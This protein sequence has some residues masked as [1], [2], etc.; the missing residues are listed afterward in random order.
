MPDA[1][2]PRLAPRATILAVA[3][4]VA[5]PAG[6][7]QA[8]VRLEQGAGLPFDES[9]LVEA[10]ALRA[11]AQAAANGVVTVAVTPSG[12]GRVA[13]DTGGRRI[14][15]EVGP[16]T[17]R[18]AARLVALLVIDVSLPSLALAEER[19]APAPG[20]LSL[21]ATPCLN[22]GLSD[23]GVSFEPT[24]GMQWRLADRLGLVLSLGYARALAV[25]RAGARVLTFDTVPLRAGLA[26][27]VGS[28]GLQAGLL[29]RGFRA[30]GV[31]AALGTR[32][33]GW[34]AASWSLPLRG[35]LRPFAIVALDAYAEKLRLDRAGRP[36]LSA[37][38]LAPW[39]GL[40]LAWNGQVGR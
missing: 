4:G 38:Y 12:P 5:T 17:G 32:Q 10:V 1:A 2:R 25:D 36:M 6:G 26:W 23:A 15:A 16:R 19:G 7:R 14:E 22:F 24:L 3:L 33:G 31:V 8:Q 13:I 30:A 40:G 28:F 11:P 9:E 35:A 37:G 21:F 29:A 39:A 18:E 20:R 27:S 34:A